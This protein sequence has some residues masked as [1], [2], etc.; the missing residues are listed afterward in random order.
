M[1]PII[2][3]P[4]IE[5]STTKL[6]IIYRWVFFIIP[7][8]YL[9]SLFII[10]DDNHYYGRIFLITFGVYIILGFVIKRP[11]TIIIGHITFNT[12]Y[13]LLTNKNSEQ[14]YFIHDIKNIV[15]TY[16]GYK[17]KILAITPTLVDT[18]DDNKLNFT[19]QK[20][21]IE[22]KIHI[23]RHEYAI[24]LMNFFKELKVKGIDIT[25]KK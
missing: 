20:Q 23:Q 12:D 24:L 7:V 21:K 1:I 4:I 10:K 22:F 19:H 11:K 9:I 6:F 3:L 14:R 16:S 2:K 5:H 18:G 13:F 17:G 15:F 25:I 8:L